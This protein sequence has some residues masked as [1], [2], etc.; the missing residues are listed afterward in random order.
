MTLWS[1]TTLTDSASV[2]PG[3]AHLVARREGVEPPNLLIRSYRRAPYP[4]RNSCRFWDIPTAMSAWIR[5][6]VVEG[7]A[8]MSYRE[9]NDG[10][11][12]AWRRQSLIVTGYDHFPRRRKLAPGR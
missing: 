5:A 10:M 11:A 9:A 6:S 3:S 12:S 4:Q 1:Y 8:S 7:S 2:S